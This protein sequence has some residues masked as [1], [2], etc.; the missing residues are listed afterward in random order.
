MCFSSVVLPLPLGAIRPYLRPARRLSLAFSSSATLSARIVKSG[1]SIPSPRPHARSETLPS[2]P[3]ST[4]NW[5]PGRAAAAERPASCAC[6]SSVVSGAPPSPGSPPSAVSYVLPPPPAAASYSFQRCSASS[7]F[8]RLRFCLPESLVPALTIARS[9]ASSVPASCGSLSLLPSAPL[10]ARPTLAPP[11]AV[12]PAS[13]PSSSLSLLL[14]LGLLLRLPPPPSAAAAAAAAAARTDLAPLPTRGV[15]APPS[16]WRRVPHGYVL[17]AFH[18]RRRPHPQ[19]PRLV[20][21]I[22][23]G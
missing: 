12:P 3:T 7:S 23:D 22:V 17:H 19:P 11:P 6:S 18:P 8:L 9:S 2:P 4:R 13:S 14:P 15:P 10:L 5:L 1:T 21:G 20:V 16:S